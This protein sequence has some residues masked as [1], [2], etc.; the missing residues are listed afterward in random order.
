[1]TLRHIDTELDRARQAG[2]TTV[3]V[4]EQVT[5]TP[6]PAEGRSW[7]LKPP[8]QWGWEEVR[9]Y[10]VHEIEARFGAFPRNFKTEHSIFK[11]FATR[12]GAQ[13]GP[14]AILAF[15]TLNGYWAGAPISVNRFCKNSDQFFAAEIAQRL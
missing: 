8:A 12:W 9:D 3:V 11:S 2:T 13:A 5:V 4:T 7:L 6:R 15:D 10:V 1:M 14:I